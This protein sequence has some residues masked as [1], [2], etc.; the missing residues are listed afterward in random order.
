MGYLVMG[1]LWFTG[2]CIKLFFLLCWWVTFNLVIRPVLWMFTL[3]FKLI[4]KL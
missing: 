3:S 4:S 2:W 1:L